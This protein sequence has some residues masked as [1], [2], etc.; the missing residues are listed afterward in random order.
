ME[1]DRRNYEGQNKGEE[2]TE[3]MSNIDKVSEEKE[4]TDS[5]SKNRHEGSIVH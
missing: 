2:L 1:S 4:R 5:V 3:R